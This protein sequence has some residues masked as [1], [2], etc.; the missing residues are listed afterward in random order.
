[1]QKSC[2]ISRKLHYK[3]F[4]I[5]LKEKISKIHKGLGRRK[6]GFEKGA[7]EEGGHA[8]R[9]GVGGPGLVRGSVGRVGRTEHMELGSEESLSL[10]VSQAAKPDA[11]RSRCHPKA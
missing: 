10:G 5:L 1:M 6:E 2:L 9:A 11:D 8:A 7:F 4:P 3:E